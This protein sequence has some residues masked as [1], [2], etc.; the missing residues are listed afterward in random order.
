MLFSYKSVFYHRSDNLSSA[1]GVMAVTLGC[2][3]LVGEEMTI[4]LLPLNCYFVVFLFKKLFLLIYSHVHT[5]FGSTLLFH[6]AVFFVLFCL[7][8]Y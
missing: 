5:S 7:L 2:V 4:H 6:N 8:W 3:H 1:I